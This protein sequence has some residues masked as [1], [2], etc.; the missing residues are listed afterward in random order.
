MKVINIQLL[1]VLI[2]TRITLRLKSLKSQTFRTTVMGLV[3][4]Q[5]KAVMEA[6]ATLTKVKEALMT[7]VQA[8]RRKKVTPYVPSNQLLSSSKA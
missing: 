6:A 1:Q 8:T 2:T 5:M 3:I 7:K 4:T